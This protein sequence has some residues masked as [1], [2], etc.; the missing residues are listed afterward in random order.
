MNDYITWCRG[1]LDIKRKLI[2]LDTETTGLADHD[3]VIQIG[4]IDRGRYNLLNT[5]VQ[6]TVPIH[7]KAAAVH[8]IT[9]EQLTDA[10]KLTDLWPA[11]TDAFMD[12]AVLGY[13]V[14]FD[15]RLLSQSCK[16]QGLK[17]VTT[18]ATIWLD[19][20]PH[21]AQHHG[22]WSDYHQSYKWQKLTD[23]CQREGI[24]ARYAHDATT[25]CRLTLD[26][27]YKLAAYPKPSPTHQ[28]RLPL[29]TA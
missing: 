14:Q 29:K 5:L 16:A 6:P 21:Y 25:D 15:K 19:L 4:I 1:V 26:L 17:D 18:L 13:N 28:Q 8:G 9:E 12:A 11:L 24:D 7:P 23:A 10:P 27:L 2:V 3:Q 22:E 20:M